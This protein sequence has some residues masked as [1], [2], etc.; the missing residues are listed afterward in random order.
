MDICPTCGQLVY[1]AKHTISD[2]EELVRILRALEGRSCYRT[3]TGTWHYTNSGSDRRVIA[4]GLISHL[5]EAGV[6]RQHYTS[7]NDSYWLG[8]TIDVDASLE[9]RRLRGKAAGLVYA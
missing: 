1:K 7:T 4:P 2:A 5:V 8:R 3:V 6:L 9:A